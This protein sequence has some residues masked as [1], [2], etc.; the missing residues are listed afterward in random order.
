MNIE[1]ANKLDFPDL[2]ARLGHQ[3]A[4]VMKD[5][6]DL[7][8]YSPFRTE[9]E[10][11]FHIQPGKIYPWVWN[12]FGHKGG[13]LFDFVCQ[14]KTLSKKDALA[15]L[16]QL[17][18]NPGSR[19]GEEKKQTSFSFRPPPPTFE[20]HAILVLTRVEPLEK[21]LPYVGSARG[22]KP[23][24]AR[25]YLKDV[26][27]ENTEKKRAYYAAGFPNRAGGYEIRNPFFKSSIGQKDV[28]F[29][30][31]AQRERLFLFEGF[32]DFLSALSDLQDAK[33]ADLRGL[34]TEDGSAF[35]GDVVVLNSASFKKTALDILASGSYKFAG[36]FF[37]NDAA[38]E[39]LRQAFSDLPVEVIHYNFLYEGHKDYNAALVKKK[40]TGTPQERLG[41]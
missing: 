5:G 22:I 39:G 18:G 24:L 12:D 4:K 19:A 16:R 32:M 21:S 3:P 40:Q 23:A 33:S 31:G 41:F 27:F 36:T 8:Y 7:W 35:A 20:I 14:Y 9:K 28:S 11:S 29:I 17:Y 30:E 37:D 2:L 15:F 25:L 1:Q 6:R 26:H 10:P 38:G 34:L 13:S